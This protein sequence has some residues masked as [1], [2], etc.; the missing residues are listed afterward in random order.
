MFFF[1]VIYMCRSIL[2]KERIK[3]F[4]QLNHC[5]NTCITG[6][7][8]GYFARALGVNFYELLEYSSA[9]RHGKPVGPVHHCDYPIINITSLS[10]K[11]KNRN[12]G[13]THTHIILITLNGNQIHNSSDCRFSS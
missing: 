12:N 2:K 5:L 13:L 11:Y 9:M 4:T 3:T 7:A 6:K 8:V 10:S 1:F